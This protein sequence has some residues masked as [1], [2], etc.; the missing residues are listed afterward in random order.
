MMPDKQLP[1]TSEA[2]NEESNVVAKIGGVER[3][4]MLL[5]ALGETDA[6]ELLKH[7]GPKEVQDVGLAMAGLTN[8]TTD[9]IEAVMRHFVSTLET[10]TAFGLG[11]SHEC[12][13]T[14]D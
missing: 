7:M 10:Q 5:L 3:S 13:P 14:E 4:A 11:Q 1:K 9:E 8:V 2:R 12:L 6:A